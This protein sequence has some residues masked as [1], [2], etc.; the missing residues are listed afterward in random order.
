MIVA[1]FIYLMSKYME[2]FLYIKAGRKTSIW[3]AHVICVFSS[4]N[5][6]DS[7]VSP[8]EASG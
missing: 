1:W 8:W 5:V 4:F 3:C 2:Y 7:S 6:F